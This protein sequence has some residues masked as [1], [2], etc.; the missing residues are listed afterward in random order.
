MGSRPDP[1]LQYE[2][3]WRA[4]L[5]LIA[6]LFAVWLA[7]S[8][9]CAYFAPELSTVSVG[10]WPLGFYMCAQGSLIVFIALVALYARQMKRLDRLMEVEEDSA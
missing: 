2:R 1:S 4:N 7:A 6:V 9:G 10:G 3:H 5:R 8:F